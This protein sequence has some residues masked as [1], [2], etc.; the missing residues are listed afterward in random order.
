M[1]TLDQ[2]VAVTITSDSVTPTAQGFGTTGILAHHSVFAERSREY[3]TV[4]EMI[5]DG[6][7][8]TTHYAILN[9]ARAIKAQNPSPPTFKVF[10]A[11]MANAVAWR[12][13]LT[14]TTATE[15]DVV[16]F[17]LVRPNGTEVDISYTVLAAA[18]TTT[19]AT[20]VELLTEAVTGLGSSSSSAVVTLLGDNV[21]EH[22]YIKDLVNCTWKDTT[23]D[24]NLGTELDAI[25]VEDNDWFYLATLIQSE[26][27][28]DEVALWAETN[29]KI[30]AFATSDDVELSSSTLFTGLVSNGYENT[31]AMF[32]RDQEG[33]AGAAFGGKF[34]PK[35]PGSWI[36][37]FQR[38][39]GVDPETLTTTQRSYLE[40]AAR[41]ANY[42]ESTSNVVHLANGITPSG[43]HI[44]S[45]V[46]QYW[47]KARLQETVF[48][49]LASADKREYTDKGFAELKGEIQSVLDR[50]VVVGYLHGGTLQLD[51]NDDDY[52]APP[53]ITMLSLA[54]IPAS[55][56]SNRHVPDIKIAA[57]EQGGIQS[58]GIEVTISV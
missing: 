33:H 36:A 10:R 34:G 25:I 57:R 27:N 55:D 37:K 28:V 48:D 39:K 14:I 42:T 13:E 41:R 5:A 3:A 40:N 45:V 50:A 21:G 35:Q 47:L 38:L 17:T 30:Y 8:E 54:D 20:A 53:T 51:P 11:A 9:M 24:A 56:R 29:E 2:I 58:V 26:A 32:S 12:G 4:A 1:S 18:T 31:F 49:W 46:A 44:D 22:F 15:G 6:F 43:R 16:S 7:S 23:A 19:V 52:I